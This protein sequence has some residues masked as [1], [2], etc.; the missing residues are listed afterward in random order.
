MAEVRIATNLSVPIG[1]TL[2]APRAIPADQRYTGVRFSA[3]PVGT[4]VTVLLEYSTDGGSTYP[5]FVQSTMH[6]GRIGVDTL[7]VF[8]SLGR[9]FVAGLITHVRGTITATQA[10]TT[11][12]FAVRD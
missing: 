8:P 7:P 10:F 4:V 1:D 12:V 9:P 6:G 5:Y 3:W 11:D 2:L